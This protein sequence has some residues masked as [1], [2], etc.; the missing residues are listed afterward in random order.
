MSASAAAAW[1]SRVV[2]LDAMNEVQVEI[3]VGAQGQEMIVIVGR[4]GR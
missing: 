2:T 3:G 1:P 4:R